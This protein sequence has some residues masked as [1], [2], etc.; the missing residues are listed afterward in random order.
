MSKIDS[1]LPVLLVPN[2]I[3]WPRLVMQIL[4]PAGP[5]E[6]WSFVPSSHCILIIASYGLP[7]LRLP[8]YHPQL[9]LQVENCPLGY[10]TCIVLANG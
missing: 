3:F 1:R 7:Q 5:L 10:R 9:R 2:T 6:I 8:K 4:R